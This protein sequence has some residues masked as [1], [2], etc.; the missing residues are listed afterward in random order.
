M[1]RLSKNLSKV[2]VSATLKKG[3]FHNK[4]ISIKSDSYTNNLYLDKKL[5][6]NVVLNKGYVLQGT[7]TAKGTVIV[8]S[9]LSL[10]NF[11]RDCIRYS[12][13]FKL[14]SSHWCIS[15]EN[16]RYPSLTFIISFSRIDYSMTSLL[17]FPCPIFEN[18]SLLHFFKFKLRK[19]TDCYFFNLSDLGKFGCRPKI[20]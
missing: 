14:V 4:Y 13:Y 1:P 3:W 8:I 10:E 12:K 15:H 20:D 6:D 11:S 9:L 19:K 7:A 17:T 5:N 18:H 16:N 2:K